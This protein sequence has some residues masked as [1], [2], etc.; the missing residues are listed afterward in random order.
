MQIKIL[1]VK[2][3]IDTGASGKQLFFILLLDL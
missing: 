3:G 2:Q 1:P